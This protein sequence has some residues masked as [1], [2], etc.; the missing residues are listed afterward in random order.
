M[1]VGGR[2]L[3]WTLLAMAAPA[4][5]CKQEGGGST[6]P[7]VELARATPVTDLA[8]IV[9]RDGPD[10]AGR[11]AQITGARVQ[12]V[13]DQRVFWIGPSD[14]RRVLVVAG[15]PVDVQ[16]DQP[17]DVTGTVERVPSAPEGL[18]PLDLAQ[19]AEDLLRIQI[20]Y[21]RASSAVQAE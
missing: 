1:K 9:G 11:P 2:L 10:L 6:P 19:Q 4:A 5:A 3:V 7:P 8:A 15:Q 17:V 21:I 12:Q 14:T 16:Q 20:V 13:V 18:R